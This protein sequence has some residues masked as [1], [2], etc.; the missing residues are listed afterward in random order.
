MYITTSCLGQEMIGL[1]IRH[2][3]ISS[4]FNLELDR[5][6]TCCFGQA[7]GAVE[8]AS[9]RVCIASDGEYDVRLSPEHI[10]SCCYTCGHG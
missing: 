3:L 1:K 6:C 4:A 10:I 8:A 5:T 7:F 2:V 9:D